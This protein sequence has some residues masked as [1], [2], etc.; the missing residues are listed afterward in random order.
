MVKNSKNQRT[1]TKE[2]KFIVKRADTKVSTI[3]KKY[4]IDLGVRSDMKL[5]NYLKK[6]GYGSL[7]GMLSK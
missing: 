3:E 2:G 4:G 6:K 7:S 5:G 1:R